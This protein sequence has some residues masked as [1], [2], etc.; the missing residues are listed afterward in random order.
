MASISKFN[1]IDRCIS[2]NEIDRIDQNKI[3]SICYRKRDVRLKYKIK[4]DSYHNLSECTRCNR[5]DYLNDEDVCRP[6]KNNTYKRKFNGN[7]RGNN[8]ER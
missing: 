4:T 5:M 8:D 7:G 1:D 6:C 3:C 2:C